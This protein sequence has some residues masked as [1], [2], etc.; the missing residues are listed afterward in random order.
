MSEGLGFSRLDASERVKQLEAEIV[1]LHVFI[2]W[3]EDNQAQVGRFEEDGMVI[4]WYKSH[5]MQASTLHGL[6]R[7]VVKAH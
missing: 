6:W 7:K 3:Y 1:D 5:R 4:W 2:A